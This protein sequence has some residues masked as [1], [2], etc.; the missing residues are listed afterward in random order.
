[1]VPKKSTMRKI[2]N[3]L[4]IQKTNDETDSGSIFAILLTFKRDTKVLTVTF[5]G[6]AKK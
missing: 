1:L 6:N 2:V 3:D 4:K 5:I